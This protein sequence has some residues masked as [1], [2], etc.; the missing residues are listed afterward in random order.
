MVARRIRNEDSIS[1]QS[2]KARLREEA[3]GAKRSQI[4]RAEDTL[5]KHKAASG[6]RQRQISAGGSK[7]YAS[8]APGMGYGGA[9]MGGL[10]Q[11]ATDIEMGKIAQQ[12]ADD[13]ITANMGQTIDDYRSKAAEYQMAAGSA[14]SDKLT[15]IADATDK[16][17]DAYLKS[18]GYVWDDEESV[19]SV[20]RTAV[21]RAKAD[22]NV[23]AAEEIRKHWLV[24]GGIGYDKIM[25]T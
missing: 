4:S 5:S 6:E 17:E 15:A 18:Q 11:V 12:T 16:I 8:S 21:A 20:A 22:G 19:F 13:A 9:L 2:E 24:P 3:V 10:A 7:A 25:K 1:A 14:E 23:D